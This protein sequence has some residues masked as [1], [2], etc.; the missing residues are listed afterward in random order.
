MDADALLERMRHVPRDWR[1]AD[2]ERVCDAFGIACTP[3]RKGSHYKVKH[4][5]MP[6]ILTIPAHRPIKPV[7]IRE[8]VRF[9]DAVR[10]Q[11]A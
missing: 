9:V 7:Y 10:E 11:H 4:P 6:L 2:I 8:L 3:P 5:S 1:I